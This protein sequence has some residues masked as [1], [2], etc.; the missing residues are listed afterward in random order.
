M[1]WSRTGVS[2]L[3]VGWGTPRARFQNPGR[4]FRV[5]TAHARASCPDGDGR[6]HEEEVLAQLTATCGGGGAPC[7]QTKGTGGSRLLTSLQARPA[8]ARARRS[9]RRVA[10]PREGKEKKKKKKTSDT[11]RRSC[12]P[13]EIFNS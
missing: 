12:L 1:R 6:D 9:P 4:E 3:P 13:I 7:A 11:P 10:R 5:L 8:H 2:T